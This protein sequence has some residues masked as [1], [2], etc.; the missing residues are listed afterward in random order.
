MNY[1]TETIKSLV[2][3]IYGFNGY[4]VS[5][6]VPGREFENALRFIT[7]VVV[8]TAVCSGKLAYLG[9]SRDPGT[10]EPWLS[11]AHSLP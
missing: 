4:M 10:G 3:R 5:P 6:K 7:L 9:N 8:V 1:P 11:P 2:G